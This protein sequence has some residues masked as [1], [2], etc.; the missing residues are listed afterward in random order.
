MLQT[1]KSSLLA[2]QRP[3]TQSGQYIVLNILDAAS[4][5]RQLGKELH[6]RWVPTQNKVDGCKK[7]RRAA[8]RATKPGR[9]PP[10]SRRSRTVACRTAEPGIE[11]ARKALVHSNPTSGRHKRG[12]DKAVP[13]THTQQPYATLS[14]NDT[15]LLSQLRTGKYRL[16]SYLGS[17]QAAEST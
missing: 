17:I 14:K 6:F 16:N 2:L 13:G 8:R 7:A 10:L 9:S 3:G 5:I 15:S 11:Q 4:Q 12:L 1:S